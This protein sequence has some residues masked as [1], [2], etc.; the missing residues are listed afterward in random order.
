V[1]LAALLLAL[2]PGDPP[3]VPLDFTPDELAAI[4]D[5]SP[6]PPPPHDPTNRWEDDPRAQHLGQFL[7]FDARLSANG[8]VSCA[9][10]H[11]ADRALADGKQFAQGLGTLTRNTPALWNEAYNRWYFLDGRADSLWAQARQPIEAPDEMGFSRVAL[12]A[13]FRSDAA[14]R[15]AYEDL[16][17][18]LPDAPA[19]AAAALLPD[20]AWPP[21]DRFYAN[22]CKCFAAHVRRLVSAHSAFDLFVAGLRDG[23]PQKLAALPAPA[24]R[25]LRLFVTHNCDLCH[26]GPNFTDMEFHSTR[27]PLAN[28]ALRHDGGRHDGTEKVLADP[29]NGA[30]AFSDA[31]AAGR[32][33]L[34]YLA[35]REDDI[36]RFKTPSLRNV[37]LTA[38]YMHAGQFATLRDVLHHYSEMDDTFDYDPGHFE[39]MLDPLHLTEQESDDLVAFLEALTDT[40]IDPA[41]TVQPA[42]PR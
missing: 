3:A 32:A 26:A 17:G 8:Q 38:P 13:L 12:L 27:V 33:K 37:A 21:I 15:A 42:G 16:F 22:V 9:T 39:Q 31:P 30:G 2:L 20:G 23:D 19:D 35:T 29:F 34:A 24:Q 36:G 18:P 6:L 41:L 1:I 14:L 11:P 7:F 40:G 25:G 28:A 5:H 4:L 10:C